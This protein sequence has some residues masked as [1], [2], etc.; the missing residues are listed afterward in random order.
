MLLKLS[1][2]V[3]RI[4]RQPVLADSPFRHKDDGR[5]GT[6]HEH[7]NRERRDNLHQGESPATRGLAKDA[8]RILHW[9][10]R[11]TVRVWV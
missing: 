4:N 6:Q 10:D 5:H 11:A 7:A 9:T 2:I 3:G 8:Q 1:C